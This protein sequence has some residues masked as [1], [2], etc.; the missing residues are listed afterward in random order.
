MDSF[1]RP[2]APLILV[3]DD[4]ADLLSIYDEYLSG[5]GFRV[6]TANNGNQAV[7]MTLAL[8]PSSVLMDL[9]LPGIDGWEA[10]RLIRSYRRTKSIPIVALSGHRDTSSVRRALAAGCNRFVP[11]PCEPEDLARIL[12]LTI[13]EES[14]RRSRM[15][16]RAGKSGSSS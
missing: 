4:S 2:R 10:A 7:T 13:Q 11:K 15:G 5:E 16:S 3:V 12:R 8:V 1:T 14:D 6:E 9:D